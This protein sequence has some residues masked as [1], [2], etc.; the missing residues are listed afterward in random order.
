LA[1]KYFTANFCAKA[2]PDTGKRQILSEQE[3]SKPHNYCLCDLCYHKRSNIQV[4]DNNAGLTFTNAPGEETWISP[5]V[6]C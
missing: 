3:L 6:Q 1:A 5:E 4:G 2:K